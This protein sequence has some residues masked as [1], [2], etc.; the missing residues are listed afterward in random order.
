[1]LARDTWLLLIALTRSVSA[2]C[3]TCSRLAS[4]FMRLQARSDYATNAL[5]M[6]AGLEITSARVACQANNQECKYEVSAV[7]VCHW[8]SLLEDVSPV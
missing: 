1:M 4:A 2:L 3:F 8:D 5:R 6:K 7:V